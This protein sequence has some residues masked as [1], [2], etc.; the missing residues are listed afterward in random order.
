MKMMITLLTYR[1][2]GIVAGEFRSKVGS[3]PRFRAFQKSEY[4]ENMKALLTN[5]WD[6]II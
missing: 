6:Y 3:R 1:L 5:S 4:N 2:I